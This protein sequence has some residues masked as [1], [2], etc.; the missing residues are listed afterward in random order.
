MDYSPPGSSLFVGFSRQE[1]WRWVATPSSRGSSQPR[2]WTHISYVSCTGRRVLYHQ[3]HLGS[4]RSSLVR[5]SFY[6]L[7]LWLL[8]NRF[9]PLNACGK[10]QTV[11]NNF[12]K[13]WNRRHFWMWLQHLPFSRNCGPTFIPLD[14]ID[15]SVTTDFSKLDWFLTNCSE[16][17]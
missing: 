14:I 16:I 9:S 13:R 3:H 12:L 6:C 5:V 8:T 17:A 4:P 11:S 10:Y 1:Y 15:L 2:D 7:E